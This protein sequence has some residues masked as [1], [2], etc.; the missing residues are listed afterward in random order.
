MTTQIKWT[1]STISE[2]YR[3][4]KFGNLLSDTYQGSV[5]LNED[6]GR[7]SGWFMDW[8]NAEYNKFRLNFASKRAA[9]R[10]VN[11]RLREILK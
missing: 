3:T 2:S 9:I 8:S 4:Q 7:W 6:T 11:A 1:K 10:W 5:D